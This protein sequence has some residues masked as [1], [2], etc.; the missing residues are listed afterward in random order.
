M[1]CVICRNGETLPGTTTVT[2]ERA[3]ATI[4]IKAVPALICE[5]CGEEYIS[6]ET[7]VSL[8]KQAE[9]YAMDGVHFHVQHYFAA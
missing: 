1:K 8:L 9:R 7:S 6:E 2:L 3:E 5:N 4:V